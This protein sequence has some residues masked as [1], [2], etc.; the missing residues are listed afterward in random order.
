MCYGIKS[1]LNNLYS[2]ITL[3]QGLCPFD[4]LQIAIPNHISFMIRSSERDRAEHGQLTHIRRIRPIR[5]TR[6]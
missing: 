2:F 1:I 4:I 6:K 5:S 3:C